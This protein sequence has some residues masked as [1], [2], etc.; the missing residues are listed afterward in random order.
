[1]CT[2]ACRVSISLKIVQAV[3]GRSK[4]LPTPGRGVQG[5]G[6]ASAILRHSLNSAPWQERRSQNPE[7]QALEK[8][9]PVALLLLYQRQPFDCLL[10]LSLM[11]LLL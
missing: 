5:L 1:M 6:A 3:F 4:E 8:F 9:Q 7:P 11:Q 2:L 10:V